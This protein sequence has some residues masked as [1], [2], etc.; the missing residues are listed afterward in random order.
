ME[1]LR[2]PLRST[3]HP[4]R[5]GDKRSSDPSL[6]MVSILIPAFNEEESIADCLASL[7]EQTY[8]HDRMEILV[9]D[10]L[11][12]DRTRDI[13]K[14]SSARHKNI[15]LHENPNRI[16]PCALNIG[17]REAK[18]D[19]VIRADAHTLYDINYVMNSVTL[20]LKTRAGNVGGVIHP[21]GKG[22]VGKAIA[23]GV[24][25]PFGV[26]NAYYRYA[27]S[28]RWVDTVAFGCWKKQTLLAIGGYN[29]TYLV[30]E[31]YELN[32]R[33]RQRGEGILLSPDLKCYYFPRSCLKGLLQQYFRYGKWKV[34]MLAEHP[35]SLVYRQ[36][37]PPLFV[38]SLFTAIAMAPLHLLPLLLV[39]GT[40]ALANLFVSVHTAAKRGSRSGFILPV[41][42][43]SI[44]LAWGMGFLSGLRHLFRFR[45]VK[46]KPA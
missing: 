39:G 2:T 35:G 4:R 28:Q 41:V 10:G 17:I 33:L 42:F 38:L 23:M 18:G 31:D 20:L 1:S 6:P 19:V 26:G 46:L 16:I 13:V 30:N 12:R 21:V 24:S 27:E 15:R 25:S 32:Y 5:T 8:P 37:I 11:S 44:H 34:K 3:S 36:V 43:F 29:E 45:S 9:I 7:F 14:E 40:Y 22:L